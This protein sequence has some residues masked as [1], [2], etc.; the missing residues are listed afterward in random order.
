MWLIYILN[1]FRTTIY[2]RN[3][4]IFAVNRFSLFIKFIWII[5]S[6]SHHLISISSFIIVEVVIIIIILIFFI[7][8]IHIS[9]YN[10]ILVHL[11]IRIMI[12]LIFRINILDWF[13]N[14]ES[15]ILIFLSLICHHRHWIA[16]IIKISESYWSS[17]TSLTGI[18]FIK[19]Y[20][21]V[22]IFR[23]SWCASSRC[24]LIYALLFFLLLL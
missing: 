5:C 22:W 13:F 4:I 12:W 23:W 15:F 9:I 8:L 17:I 24:F 11:C 3:F 2:S 14:N 7:N 19:Y 16:R 10:I 18:R 21:S 1:I 20:Y 6:F